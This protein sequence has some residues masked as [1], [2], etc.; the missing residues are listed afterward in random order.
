MCTTDL[1]F[2]KNPAESIG[3]MNV[4]TSMDATASIV[5]TY[6]FQDNRTLCVKKKQVAKWSDA[7]DLPQKIRAPIHQ[8]SAIQDSQVRKAHVFQA[9]LAAVYLN[10]GYDIIRDWIHKLINES[11]ADILATAEAEE[12]AE[13]MANLRTD[14]DSTAGTSGSISTPTA[15]ALPL[16]PSVASG[17]PPRSPSIATNPGSPNSS[18]TYTALLHE[19]CAQLR[20]NP[21]EWTS[22]EKGQPHQRTYTMNVKSKCQ[23]VR[24][25]HANSSF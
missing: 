18:K 22:T 17:S 21:P 15:T 19:M 7:Y 9:Y 2:N 5:P 6:L 23:M 1:F 25:I 13:R 12:L 24:S 4:S 10:R 16:S 14:T 3:V 20:Y 11:W 8:Q